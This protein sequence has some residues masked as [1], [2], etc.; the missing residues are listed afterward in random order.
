MSTT[1]RDAGEGLEGGVAFVQKV[2]AEYAERIGKVVPDG[3][4]RTD[5]LM[6]IS[7]AQALLEQQLFLQFRDRVK[8]AD[9]S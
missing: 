1:G 3:P 4:L 2:T 6:R 5:A 7:E 8:G 9:N